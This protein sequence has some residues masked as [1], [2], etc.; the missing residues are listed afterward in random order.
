MSKSVDMV[1]SVHINVRIPDGMDST[2]VTMAVTKQVETVLN[3]ANRQGALAPKGTLTEV[4]KVLG[5]SMPSAPTDD[6]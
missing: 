2:A 1:V 6:S 4:G 5:V 3:L